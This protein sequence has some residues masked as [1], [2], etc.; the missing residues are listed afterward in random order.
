[1]LLSGKLQSPS[2]F[3]TAFG[4]AGSYPLRSAIRR[5]SVSRPHR[6]AVATSCER[7]YFPTIGR[8]YRKICNPLKRQH[9]TDPLPEQN[10]HRMPACTILLFWQSGIHGQA[11]CVHANLLAQKGVAFH[12]PARTKR[13][14]RYQAYESGQGTRYRN[15]IQKLYRRD[16]RRYLTR[17][18]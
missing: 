6:V 15:S 17:S 18:E 11:L 16:S 7:S 14:P 1:M 3:R 4:S 13:S 8:G 9:F 10:V 12:H 5:G 2:G